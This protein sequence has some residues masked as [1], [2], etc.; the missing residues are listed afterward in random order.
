MVQIG[1]LVS[2]FAFA[3]IAETTSEPATSAWAWRQWLVAGFALWSIS[4]GHRFRRWIRQRSERAL[5]G[6]DLD[7]KA[8]RKWDAAQLASLGNAESVAVWGVFV[9]LSLHGAR[10]QAVPFYF[11][12][13]FF[14]LLWTPRPLVKE[15]SAPV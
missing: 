2:V 9:R 14:L 3:A 4:A 15:G 5:S 10:W 13:L 8:V 11:V 1:L 6:G 12:A 7:G